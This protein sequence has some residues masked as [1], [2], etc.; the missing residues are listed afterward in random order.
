MSNKLGVSC[1]RCL[2]L[3]F[4]ALATVAV[5]VTIANSAAT[6]MQLPAPLPPGINTIISSIVQGVDGFFSELVKLATNPHSSPT[7]VSTG[8]NSTLSSIGNVI[9]SIFD[10]IAGILSGSQSSTTGGTSTASGSALPAIEYSISGYMNGAMNLTPYQHSNPITIMITKR[11]NSTSD[12]YFTIKLALNSEYVIFTDLHNNSITGCGPYVI[13]VL[14]ES[15]GE[16]CQFEV[17]A[18]PA[19]QGGNYTVYTASATAYYNGSVEKNLVAGSS[20]NPF[21]WKVTV[22]N[23]LKT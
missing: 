15:N 11:D 23:Q 8:T 2:L 18:L 7:S 10:S 22:T 19:T 4:A 12:H 3:V 1:N 6:L 16:I 21:S 9:H 13:D 17:Y 20:R 5:L 14:N